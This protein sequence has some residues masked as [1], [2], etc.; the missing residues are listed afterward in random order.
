MTNPEIKIKITPGKRVS[1]GNSSKTIQP[2]RK[3]VKIP[4]QPKGAN[5]AAGALR[6]AYIKN[7]TPKPPQ[8]AIEV[9]K[10]PSIRDFIGVK[11]I[12]PKASII[13]PRAAE[14]AEYRNRI[15][16]DTELLKLRKVTIEEA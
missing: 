1:I 2:I 11:V 14:I 5:K 3:E 15:A 12:D 6:K 16:L 4:K 8:T 13:A 9:I 7:T 10:R